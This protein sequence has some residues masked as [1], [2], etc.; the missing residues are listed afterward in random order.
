MR[1][2]KKVND[3]PLDEEIMQ[4]QPVSVKAW[5]QK[6]VIAL[7]CVASFYAGWKSHESNMVNQ[8]YASGG[9]V[10]E[11]ERTMLCQIS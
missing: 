7:L 3:N 9:Q 11:G 4:Q 5:M 2:Q 6:L 8:C 10:I 1:D